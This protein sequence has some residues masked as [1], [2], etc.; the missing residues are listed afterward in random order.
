[1]GG[2][3]RPPEGSLGGGMARVVSGCKTVEA[4]WL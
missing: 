2:P 1:V 4:N 3:S